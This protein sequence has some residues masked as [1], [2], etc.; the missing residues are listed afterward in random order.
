LTETTPAAWDEVELGEIVTL[1]RW[2]DLP[3]GQRR[4]GG[5]PVVSSSGITGYHDEA[6]I[7]P[8]G[9]VTGRYGT[10]GEVFFVEEPFWPLNTTLY[11]SD[12]HGNDERFVSYLLRCQRIGAHDAAAAVPG[13]NRNVL[14][15][16]PARR[17]PLSTQRKI[18]AILSAYDDLI[19]NSN[20]RVRILEEAARCIYREWFADFRYRGHENARL[21]DSELGPIPAGWETARLGSVA[22]NLDRKRRPLSGVV[23]ARRPGPYPYYGA[24]RIFDYIDD[25]IFAGTYLL[26]AEDGSVITPDGAAVLQYVSGKFWANNHTH[27]LRGTRLSTEYLYLLL[28]DVPISGYITGAAQPKITQASLNR[29]PCVVPGPDVAAAFNAIIQPV[30]RERQLLGS[31]AGSL[32]AARDLLLPRLISGDVDVTDLGILLPPQQVL[33]CP[34]WPGGSASSTSGSP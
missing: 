12:F 11:V 4:N 26:V 7:S 16:L 29:I 21:A 33:T 9:V 14:H 10:L 19:E 1:H 23:R 22:E 25:Y 3:S 20:R 8:P 18:A 6:K 27:I 31:L 30:F 15:R 2:Y 5:I 34:S 17:P 13:V 24:A 28:S 32:R